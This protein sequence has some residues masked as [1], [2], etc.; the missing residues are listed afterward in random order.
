MMDDV[1]VAPTPQH[2]RVHFELEATRKDQRQVLQLLK[3]SPVFES[4][5][6]LGPVNI[7]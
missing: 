6:W 1:Q 2:V 3:Q 7:E 5:T 4:A